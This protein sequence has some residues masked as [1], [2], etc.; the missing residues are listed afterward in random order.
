MF[1]CTF[2]PN[3]LFLTNVDKS[4]K[5][6][7]HSIS[8]LC[9]SWSNFSHQIKSKNQN[10]LLH[11]WVPS[12]SL[13]TSSAPLH[14]CSKNVAWSEKNRKIFSGQN[15]HTPTHL[16]NLGSI[17]LFWPQGE[18][19][20]SSHVVSTLGIYCWRFSVQGRPHERLFVFFFLTNRVDNWLIVVWLLYTLTTVI[21][22]YRQ[23]FDTKGT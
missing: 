2:V 20:F 18:G 6:L 15:P 11:S 12:L 14:I 8:Y 3:S 19:W 17:H 10:F 16:R 13:L 1:W 21:I 7:I 9:G 5:M 22:T 4:A 23:R